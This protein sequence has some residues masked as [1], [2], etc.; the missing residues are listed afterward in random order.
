MHVIFSFDV[1]KVYIYIHNVLLFENECL[2]V[3]VYVAC[4]C[5]DSLCQW[6]HFHFTLIDVLTYYM[7]DNLKLYIRL[8]C[9]LLSLPLFISLSLSSISLPL[10]IFPSSFSPSLF[11]SLPPSHSNQYDRKLEEVQKD[12]L[13]THT[14]A[15]STL[16][17]YQLWQQVSV[18][19]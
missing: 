18:T 2:F 10:F 14:T 9:F 17:L 1:V 12:I 15:I 11:L 6:H 13:H 19:T 7:G 16:M 4:M 3:Y 5:Y 8:L